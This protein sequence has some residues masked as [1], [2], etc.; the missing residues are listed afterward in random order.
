[1]HLVKVQLLNPGEVYS[2]FGDWLGNQALVSSLTACIRAEREVAAEHYERRYS[3]AP[4][5]LHEVSAERLREILRD[6]ADIHGISAQREISNV[7]SFNNP[8]LEDN[9]QSDEVA[10]LRADIDRQVIGRIR[11][12]FPR[13]K[14]CRI[15]QSGHFWYPRG[16]YMGWH[17]NSRFPG[18]RFYVTYAEEPGKAFFRYRHPDTREIHT[19]YDNG[20]GMR[21]FYVDP[22]KPFWHAVYS[23]TDRFSFGYVVHEPSLTK[24]IMRIVNRLR[25]SS[26]PAHV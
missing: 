11:N 15:T 22:A 17:T 18:W 2:E 13:A 21:M 12:A 23:D 6:G 26:A 16:G 25:S 5:A 19:S 3:P 8:R 1:M 24:S 10:A 14:R 7:I 4:S 20:W 9:V